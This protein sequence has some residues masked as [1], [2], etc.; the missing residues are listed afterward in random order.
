MSSRVGPKVCVF[1]CH[2]LEKM[3]LS[4][5]AAMRPWMDFDLKFGQYFP[6]VDET[7]LCTLLNNAVVR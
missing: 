5:P 6:P 7:W 4:G 1:M 2:F 3:E